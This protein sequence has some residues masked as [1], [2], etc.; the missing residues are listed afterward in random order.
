[1]VRSKT[2]PVE[3]NTVDSRLYYVHGYRKKLPFNQISES[4]RTAL[5]I[6]RTGSPRLLV[7]Y[8]PRIA[9]DANRRSIFTCIPM[10]LAARTKSAVYP[11][12][13]QDW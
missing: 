11:R 7:P 13:V 9:R 2:E 6:V 3:A 1:M 10:G 5:L 4:T 12:T 8:R